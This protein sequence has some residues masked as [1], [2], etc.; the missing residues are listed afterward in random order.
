MTSRE[1]ILVT[2]DGKKSEKIPWIPLCSRT[3]FLSIPEYR[4]KF[5]PMSPAGSQ[6]GLS[7]ELIW[8]ELEFRVKFY[9]KIGADFMD[10]GG[11]WREGREYTVEKEKKANVKIIQKIKNDKFI[12]I[13]E[14]PIGTL[15]QEFVFSDNKSTVLACTPLLKN[16]KD[17]KVYK[18]ILE[19]SIISRPNYEKSKKWLDIVGESGVIF[20]AGPIAP[21][22]EWIFTVLGVEGVVYGL[23][24]HRAELEELIKLQHRRNFEICRILS[25]SPLK[26]FLN[27]GVIGTGE[28]SPSIFE[29]Y[30]LPYL[31]EYSR[32]LREGN[33]IYI[34]HASGE[35][36]R[37]ILGLV[38]EIN[39]FGMYG[40][41]SPPPKGDLSLSELCKRWEGKGVVMG[42]IDPHFLATANVS[43]IKERTKRI[44]Q[45]VVSFSNFI[46]GTAD[47]VVYGTPTQ[48]LEAVSSAVRDFVG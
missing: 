17:Y 6:P 9:Q 30:Y 4:K 48:N 42:G 44:L 32:I 22:Q 38:E 18:Y 20:R 13:Y 34:G 45:E 24:D 11:G 1:C 10:W 39:L 28:I 47:D 33:K 7:K 31:K 36:I 29:N 40:L 35:P 23:R 15:K 43:Q 8:E 25:V 41:V 26:I 5:K 46:L 16:K 2:F 27:A 19:S 14:T 37:P 21:I 3:F 12:D